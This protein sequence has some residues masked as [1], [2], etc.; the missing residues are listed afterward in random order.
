M[1]ASKEVRSKGFP[2]WEDFW[3]DDE[4]WKWKRPESDGRGNYNRIN[5][6]VKQAEREEKLEDR[7]HAMQRQRTAADKLEYRPLTSVQAFKRK[8]N[9]AKAHGHQR[10]QWAEHEESESYPTFP[11]VPPL[12]QQIHRPYVPEKREPRPSHQGAKKWES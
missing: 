9:C 4:L 7:F 1:N 10:R 6:L 5:F 11:E 3:K 8:I 12:R 2:R